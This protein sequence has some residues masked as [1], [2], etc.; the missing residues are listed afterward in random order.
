MEA[1]GE[2]EAREEASDTEGG[3][4]GGCDFEMPQEGTVAGDEL[5]IGFNQSDWSG[6]QSHDILVVAALRLE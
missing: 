5:A 2:R 1:G 6:Q 4:F 3:E